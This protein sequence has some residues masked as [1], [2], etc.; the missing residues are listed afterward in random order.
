[1]NIVVGNLSDVPVLALDKYSLTFPVKYKVDPAVEPMCGLGGSHVLN[2][3]PVAAKVRGQK[4]FEILPAGLRQAVAPCRAV[5]LQSP[6]HLM[7]PAHST[8]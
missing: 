5:P 3:E 4:A 8:W 7:T 1:M 6:T 2:L